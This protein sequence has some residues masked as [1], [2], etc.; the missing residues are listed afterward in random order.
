MSLHLTRRSETQIR[1]WAIAKLLL[2]WSTL[3]QVLFHDPIGPRRNH[4]RNGWLARSSRLETATL[5]TK[6][7]VGSQHALCRRAVPVPMK[8]AKVR[9]MAFSVTEPPSHAPSQARRCRPN[10]RSRPDA[11]AP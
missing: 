8:A 3:R 5:S 10:I 11:Q 4:R 7:T 9:L 2:L 6:A 1:R